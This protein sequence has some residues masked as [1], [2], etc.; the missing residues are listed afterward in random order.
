MTNDDENTQKLV[1]IGMP[2]RN[3]ASHIR[4][5]IES[6]LKQTYQNI[7]IVVC[8]NGSNDATGDICRVF[9]DADPRLHYNRSEEDV[10]AL[11]NFDRALKTARGPFFAW[12]AHD[13][14]WEP[15]FV[16]QLVARLTAHRDSVLAFCMIDNVDENGSP[17]RTY[18]RL[19][20]LAGSHPSTVR[21]FLAQPEEHGKANL[22]YALTRTDVLRSIGPLA[23]ASYTGWGA[24]MIVVLGV[25]CHGDVEI[26]PDLL[27]HKRL[28]PDAEPDPVPPIVERLRK[29]HDYQRAAREV[30]RTSRTFST[31]TRARLVTTTW[32]REVSMVSAELSYQVGTALRRRLH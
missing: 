21:R 15:T 6:L 23:T 27:F 19:K 22:I 20:E 32:L 5:A 25:V 3:G 10:G 13:D 24:D 1:S 7:E 16:E 12:A 11:A 2:V 14:I 4:R 31:H 29:A 30:L 26:V 9:A 8:D 28:I 17:F 18:P